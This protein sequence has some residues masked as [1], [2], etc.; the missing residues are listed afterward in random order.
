M[1]GEQQEGPVL[2]A[3]DGSELA[4]AAIEQA[5]SQLAP[6]REAL[7]VLVWQPADVGFEPVGDRPF[8][9]ADASAVRAAAQDTAARGAQL[10]QQAGLRA[11]TVCC[12]CAPTWKGI[13]ETAQEH[14]ASLIVIGSHV[15]RGVAGHLLGSVARDVIAHTTLPVLVTQQRD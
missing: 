7:V 13:V 6:G 3:Y 8:D 1:A 15:R 5:A 11:R 10:A 4:G 9:A 12:N 2:F 14:E